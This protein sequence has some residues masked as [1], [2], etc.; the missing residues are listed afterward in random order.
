MIEKK[1]EYL[2]STKIR[3]ILKTPDTTKIDFDYLK[4]NMKQV[5]ILY[6][7]SN[8]LYTIPQD[9]FDIKTN[10]RKLVWVN[11]Y[12]ET[13]RIQKNSEYYLMSSSENDLRNFKWENIN[14]MDIEAFKKTY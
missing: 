13:N 5:N 6:A 14:P 4:N 3:E 1:T 8:K 10:T 9:D 2:S 7:L 12:N 11:S